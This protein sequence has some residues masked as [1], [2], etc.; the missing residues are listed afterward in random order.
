MP[1]PCGGSARGQRGTQEGSDRTVYTLGEREVAPGPGTLPG[2]VQHDSP[3]CW[4]QWGPWLG[5]FAAI[6]GGGRRGGSGQTPNTFAGEAGTVGGGGGGLLMGRG[7]SKRVK[8]DSEQLAGRKRN[9]GG[10]AWAPRQ[11]QAP[12]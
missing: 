7:V 2:S 11:E 6:C 9:S 8:A 1:Q 3:S 10:P 12:R 4:V 5:G